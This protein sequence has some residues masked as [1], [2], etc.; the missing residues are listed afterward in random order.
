MASLGI[1]NRLSNSPLTSLVSNPNF[2]AGSIKPSTFVPFLSALA[3]WRIR[4]IGIYNLW[5]ADINAKQ[6]APYSVI[7]CFFKFVFGIF[8]IYFVKIRLLT[9]IILQGKKNIKVVF[10]FG[11]L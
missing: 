11:I 10:Y 2:S 7:L 8:T 5:S 3:N 4:A 6:V 9:A 1:L